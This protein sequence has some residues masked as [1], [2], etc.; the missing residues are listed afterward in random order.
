MT[1]ETIAF[2]TDLDPQDHPVNNLEM[3]IDRPVHI[4]EIWENITGMVANLEHLMQSMDIETR[5]TH[6]GDLTGLISQV[7]TISEQ[8]QKLAEQ[9]RRKLKEASFFLGAE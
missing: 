3:R 9:S 4:N 7:H 1:D 5:T 2:E 6:V 8:I